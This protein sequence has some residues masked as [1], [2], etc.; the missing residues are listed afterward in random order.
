MTTWDLFLFLCFTQVKTKPH[1][2]VQNCVLILELGAVS[3]KKAAS[4]IFQ[5]WEGSL[6]H[7]EKVSMQ[8]VICHGW[9]CSLHHMAEVRKQPLWYAK[10][11]KAA[12]VHETEWESSLHEMPKVI[13]QSLSY[14]W[15][16]NTA[17]VIWKRWESFLHQ[18]VA[19]RRL[20]PYDRVEKAASFIYQRWQGCLHQMTEV[21]MQPLSYGRVRML[22]TKYGSGEKDRLHHARGEK[23]APVIQQMWKS[24]H[25][26]MPQMRNQTLSYATGERAA[27]MLYP[28]WE[29][30]LHHTAEMRRLAFA[31]EYIKI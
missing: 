13:R 5:R 10:D 15:G 29:G 28:R 26:H 14:D 18:I 2:E 9:E 19:V 8:V 16:G 7:M 23:T 1:D 31:N 6:C 3:N 12:I 20:P 17:S 22:P 11:K 27:S 30:S 24:R 25:P 21:G 4:I